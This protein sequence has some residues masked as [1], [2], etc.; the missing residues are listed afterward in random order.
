MGAN[1]PRFLDRNRT[2]VHWLTPSIPADPLKPPQSPTTTP[3]RSIRTSQ[4]HRARTIDGGATVPASSSPTSP[5]RRRS[6]ER[7]TELHFRTQRSPRIAYRFQPQTRSTSPR[8][9]DPL[10]THPR[11]TPQR[12]TDGLQAHS[13]PTS[14]Q[15]PTHSRL[16]TRSTDNR[17]DGRGKH[18]L[19]SCAAINERFDDAARANKL[20]TQP[21][22][23]NLTQIFQTEYIGNPTP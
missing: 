19:K 23:T 15:P 20:T 11:P 10:Q 2:H 5:V 6:G 9:A 12:T 13:R 17:H 3:A 7:H 4:Q 14:V 8:I 1:D 16:T 22:N 21:A 18:T